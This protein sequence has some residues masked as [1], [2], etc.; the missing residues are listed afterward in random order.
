MESP[1][2]FAHLKATDLPI[3]FNCSAGKDRTGTAAALVLRALGVPR[4][5][6]VEDF[7]LTNTVLNLQAILLRHPGSSLA[8]QPAEV[9]TAITTADP[10]YI[11]AAL[12]SI[13]RRHGRIVGFLR[14]Q[15]DVSE[16]E[17]QG[18]KEALL[19]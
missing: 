11:Q 4:D 12:D 13:D 3:I 10:A 7:V 15:L 14:E 2:S 16:A 9:I 6:V 8:K 1:E 18:I 19:E 5:T 17:L